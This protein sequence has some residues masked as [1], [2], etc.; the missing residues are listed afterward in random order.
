[1]S[2]EGQLWLPN[3]VGILKKKED[4]KEERGKQ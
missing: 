4:E 2:K 1:M 3:I